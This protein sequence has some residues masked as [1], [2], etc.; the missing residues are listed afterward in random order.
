MTVMILPTKNSQT[1]IYDQLGHDIAF[2]KIHNINR[3]DYLSH[4]SSR[5]S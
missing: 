1:N 5:S 2:K 4:A 3:N